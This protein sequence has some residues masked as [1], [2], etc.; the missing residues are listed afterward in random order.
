M[1]NNE[2]SGLVLSSA[3]I[4]Y[5]KNNFK[6][7]NYSYKFLFV[8]ETIGPLTYLSKNLKSLKKNTIA[9]FVLS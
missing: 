5:I 4:K 1:A 3:L 2:L 8:P 9:G 6:K 7:T